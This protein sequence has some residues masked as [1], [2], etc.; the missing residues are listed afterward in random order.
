MYVGADES[1]INPNNGIHFPAFGSLYKKYYVI[2]LNLYQGP[3]H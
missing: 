2:K 1:T 3:S